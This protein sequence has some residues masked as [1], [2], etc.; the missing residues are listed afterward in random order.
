MV[1]GILAMAVMVFAMSARARAEDAFVGTWKLNLAKSQ[2][3]PNHRPLDG[4]MTFEVGPDGSYLMTAE[5]TKE[6]GEKVKEHPQSFLVDGQPRPIPEMPALSGVATKPDPNTI[7]GEARRQD[8][9]VVGSATYV[10]SPDG[11]SLKA[12]VSGTDDQLRSFTQITV[13]DRQ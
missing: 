11:R 6:G 12:T 1:K 2:F 9:S 10:V 8:G 7:R 13:W 3:D 4:T 5:G